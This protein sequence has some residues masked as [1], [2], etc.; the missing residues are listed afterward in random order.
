[1]SYTVSGGTEGVDWTSTIVNNIETLTF[2][3][4]GITYTL[5]V[6]E[7]LSNANYLLVG[8]GGGALNQGGGGGGGGYVNVNS[9]TTSLATGTYTIVVGAGG[10]AIASGTVQ[11][12][13]NNGSVSS[14]TFNG[15]SYLTA[16]GGFGGKNLGG[17]S[18]GTVTG[19]AA[20]AGANGSTDGTGLGTTGT[21]GT[22]AGAGGNGG[23]GTTRNGGRGGA[24]GINGG[25][26]GYGGN[27]ATGGRG[28]AGGAGGDGTQWLASS[29]GNNI[30][31]GGGGGARGG[32]GTSN[33]AGGI[34]GLGGGGTA[35][36]LGTTQTAGLKNRGGGSGSGNT[37]SS[38][39]GAIGGGSGIVIL[40]FTVPPPYA[41]FKED[42]KI[43]TDQGYKMIQDLRKGELVKTLLHGF[44]PIDLIGKR[45]IV[46]S[47]LKERIKDQLYKCTRMQYPEVFADLILTGCHSILVDDFISEE[48]KKKS[49]EINNGRIFITDNKYRLPACLDERTKV[50]EVEGTYTIYHLALENDD[51]YMNYGIY[52]NGLLVESCSKGYLK[53]LSGM[54]LI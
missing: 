23:N 2:L 45:D 33:G 4:T 53:E 40:N 37:G 31:Y 30:Y 11:T 5:Q 54:E 36:G 22:G 7:T 46:H 8:G 14:I 13:A 38:T 35:S 10:A 42:T 21:A 50:Y 16:N 48:E 6:N 41:C 29:G 43:L 19:N 3:T 27:S 34:G 52:A 49:I 44:K 51:Y 26:G 20:S 12:A 28:G 15:S 9:A 24:G 39:S 25:A 18:G 17:G 1:M 32:T 47:A